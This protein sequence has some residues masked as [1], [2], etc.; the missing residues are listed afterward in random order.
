MTPPATL[1]ADGVLASHSAVTA[2]PFFVPTLIVVA[3][4][5]VVI[6]RDRRRPPPEEAER[7][8]AERDDSPKAPRRSRPG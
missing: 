1:T 7:E 5:G 3:V 6:W 8:E 2:L 4:I